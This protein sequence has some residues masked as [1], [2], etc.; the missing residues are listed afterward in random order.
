[1]LYLS[2]LP[3]NTQSLFFRRYSFCKRNRVTWGTCQECFV[4]ADFGASG[5]YSLCMPRKGPSHRWNL[6]IQQS[7]SKIT[8]WT[9]KSFVPPKIYEIPQNTTKLSILECE[10][11]CPWY[12]IRVAIARR[13]KRAMAVAIG[14]AVPWK[15][16]FFFFFFG[17]GLGPDVLRDCHKWISNCVLVYLYMYDMYVCIYIFFFDTSIIDYGIG[18]DVD[19]TI[20]HVQLIEL[21]DKIWQT[22]QIFLKSYFI[23]SQKTAPNT[24]EQHC[25]AQTS[26]KTAGEK[27]I[28]W[29]WL[30][31]FSS[32]EM[33]NDWPWTAHYVRN[34]AFEPQVQRAVS[35]ERG[36]ISSTWKVYIPTVCDNDISVMMVTIY[37]K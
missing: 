35:T 37:L 10:E 3:S 34:W 21:S 13:M 16:F 19:Q 12:P 8:T 30:S 22:L 20:K 29:F 1:M 17:G 33:A 2:L 14:S 26:T 11:M 27:D 24:A 6:E 4:V 18:R 5:A 36:H 31:C 28:W 25:P 7:P 15:M 32:F 23:N 9:K